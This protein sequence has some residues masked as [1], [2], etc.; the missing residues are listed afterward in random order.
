MLFELEQR[1]FDAFLSFD[2]ASW[3]HHSSIFTPN[4]FF[5]PDAIHFTLLR[6]CWCRFSSAPAS[7]VIS[8]TNADIVIGEARAR[9]ARATYII[10]DAIFSPFSPCWYYADIDTC[11]YFAFSSLTLIFPWLLFIIAA[12]CRCHAVTP[13]AMPL[14]CH[15][16]CWYAISPYFLPDAFAIIAA[17]AAMPLMPC[18]YAAV[19]HFDIMPYDIDFSAWLL[20]SPCWYATL[21]LRYW[22][23]MRCLLL[24]WCHFRCHWYAWYFIIIAIIFFRHY[25]FA[26][27]RY[28]FSLLRHYA[29]AFSY[30]F[31]LL[32]L[33]IH[34][35]ARIWQP[36]M[37][38]CQRYAATPCHTLHIIAAVS[39]AFAFIISY[40]AAMPP[41][42][43]WYA[44]RHT[45]LSYNNVTMFRY[46][47]WPSPRHL[48]FYAWCC[49]TDA[50][51]RCHYYYTLSP[52][53][54]RHFHAA[55][56]LCRSL[57]FAYAFAVTLRLSLDISM[58]PL[59]L[60]TCCHA[61][62]FCHFSATPETPA[63]LATL[64][65]CCWYYY[66]IFAFAA[67]CL[68]FS[69]F[70]PLLL[71]TA[72]FSLFA[73]LSMPFFATLCY[74]SL[75]SCFIITL[76]MPLLRLLRMTLRLY[77]TAATTLHMLLLPR[78]HGYFS[79]MPCFRYVTLP[80]WLMPLLIT[81]VAI[82]AAT[83][84]RVISLYWC[85]FSLMS[86]IAMLRQ[87]RRDADAYFTYWCHA[88]FRLML[89][90]LT[91][92]IISDDIAYFYAVDYAS[93]RSSCRHITLLDYVF[94]FFATMP[95]LRCYAWYFAW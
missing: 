9:H 48:L 64:S 69:I 1:Y 65:R 46:R 38:I 44:F 75:F 50:A 56:Q 24:R 3:R 25:Y 7:F 81:I 19:R 67:A 66:A 55:F 74:F 53:A 72:D 31:S 40:A 83:P 62:I 42:R 71:F 15:A 89:L 8:V 6:C 61:A 84:I 5:F 70:S 4:E 39:Y 79:H 28:Y 18:R 87:L 32:L 30:L 11:H 17:Y 41:L 57:I 86:A 16:I 88:D 34:T 78:Y 77:V 82:T 37:F 85:C 49:H 43:W 12:C 20:I 68:Y 35:Y 95:P 92:M 63:P 54:I 29:A 60:Y 93:L 47:R 14:R 10:A 52:V 2:M 51:I 58:L 91:L 21:H 90:M 13:A 94:F 45:F 73:T 36:L 22:C 76:F 59:S 33:I 23:V 80:R 27:L 26:T